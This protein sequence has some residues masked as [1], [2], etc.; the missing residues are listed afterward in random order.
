M[1]EEAVAS[2]A[3]SREAAEGLTVQPIE[4]TSTNA[5]ESRADGNRIWGPGIGTSY[6][7][8]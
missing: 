5:G 8:R 4:T 2:A 7:I 3:A 6:L 1:A